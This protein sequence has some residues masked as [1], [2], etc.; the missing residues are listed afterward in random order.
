MKACLECCTDVLGPAELRRQ[1][2]ELDLVNILVKKLEAGNRHEVRMSLSCLEILGTFAKCLYIRYISDSGILGSEDAL[3]LAS[4]VTDNMKRLKDKGK[5]DQK[6]GVKVLAGLA[7][8]CKHVLP[9][10]SANTL[11]SCPAA[12]ERAIEPHVIGIV[13]MLLPPSG[14]PPPRR[15]QLFGPATAVHDLC[16]NGTF[17]VVLP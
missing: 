3:E 14:G 5:K 11:M 8:T 15:A 16:K 10:S 17:G 13:K 2:K 9:S 7:Q 4:I 1:V 6:K 12:G